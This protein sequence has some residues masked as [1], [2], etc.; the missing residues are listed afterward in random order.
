MNTHPRHEEI[1]QAIKALP[2]WDNPKNFAQSE[3][4]N[5]YTDDELVEE[6]GWIEDK[7]LTPKQAVKEVKA[8]CS[9]RHS[10]RTD[11]EQSGF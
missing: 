3:I 11:I 6:F 5:C 8:R 4:S 7:A 2:L 10:I 1:V 9:L